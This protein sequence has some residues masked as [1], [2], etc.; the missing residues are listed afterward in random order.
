MKSIFSIRTKA[1]LLGASFGASAL[2]VQT[3]L[4]RAVME[5]AAG[6]ALAVSAA[7]GAWFF[8]IALGASAGGL[9]VR[10]IKSASKA[11]FYCSLL[12][13]P[14]GLELIFLAGA[15]RLWLKVG[16]GELIPFETLLAWSAVTCAPFAFLVGISFPVLARMAAESYSFEREST[17]AAVGGLWAAEAA[18]A[19]L[20]GLLF[21]LILAGR[22]TPI[23]NICLFA[24]LPPLV[25]ACSG[26]YHGR[27][28]RIFSI[29][30]I[31]AVLLVIISST[32]LENYFLRLRWEGLGSQGKMEVCQWTLYRNLLFASLEGQ[33][34]VYDNGLPSF[35]FPDHYSDAS[36][37]SILLAQVPSPERILVVGPSAYGPA[38]AWLSSGV[39]E[40]VSVHPDEDLERLLLNHLPEEMQGQLRTGGYRYVKDDGRVFLARQARRPPPPAGAGGAAGWDLGGFKHDW[41]I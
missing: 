27:P 24:S 29:F 35:S 1:Y 41:L 14:L 19:L 5:A 32:R 10:L 16:P 2:I 33:T 28:G 8:W 26:I 25:G 37:L 38:Q 20:S 6:G 18:G 39:K 23:V 11:A 13:L 3:E 12:S 36:F 7:L 17:P 40:V 34:T 21:T 30:V 9:L 31:P 4:L 22:T 15:P